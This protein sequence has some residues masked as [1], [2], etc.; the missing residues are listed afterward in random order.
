MHR[1]GRVTLGATVE[2]DATASART[3]LEYPKGQSSSRSHDHKNKSEPPVHREHHA[4][5]T[6]TCPAGAKLM[7]VMAERISRLQA[8]QGRR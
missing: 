6:H 1:E 4:G 2:A 8:F 5:W 3:R 7:D